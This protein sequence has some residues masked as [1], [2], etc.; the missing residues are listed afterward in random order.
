[1]AIDSAEIFFAIGLISFLDCFIQPQII[2]LMMAL[3]YRYLFILDILNKNS[4][5]LFYYLWSFKTTSN[6][7][8]FCR[9]L[10]P[11]NMSI[12]L[13][14]T[15]IKKKSY[16]SSATIH[17]DLTWYWLSTE[18]WCNISLNSTVW[19]QMNLWITESWTWN[20]TEFSNSL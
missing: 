16:Q 17:I 13:D 3:L 6:K 2:F 20:W 12:L 14:I 11:R 5:V 7:Y 19:P 8:F 9:Y 15:L 10:L 4:K 1:M 18:I